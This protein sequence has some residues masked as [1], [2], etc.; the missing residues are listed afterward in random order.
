MVGSEVGPES[1]AG[2]DVSSQPSVETDASGWAVVTLRGEQDLFEAK[3][4][5][6][7]LDEG[8]TAGSGRVVVDLSDVTFSDSSLLG[9]LVGTAKMARR[10]GCKVRVVTSDEWMTRKLDITGLRKVF[11]V[12]PTL[13]DAL[14]GSP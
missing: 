2:I 6:A 13:S 1:A 9:A 4:S 11:R 10:H 3:R 8:I 12:F 5:R 14:E 7:A